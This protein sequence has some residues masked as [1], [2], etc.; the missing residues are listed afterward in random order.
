MAGW[1]GWAEILQYQYTGG[2]GQP[3]ALR[4]W[5]TAALKF[6][7]G[8]FDRILEPAPFSPTRQEL[9]DRGVKGMACLQEI[10]TVAPG[11]ADAYLEAVASRWL[12]VAERRGLTL[13][14]AWRTAMRDTEA[15]L[16]WSLPTFRAYTAHLADFRSAPET[17]AW[18]ETAR[19]WRTDHRET[20]IVPSIW[21]VTHPAWRGTPARA[22][23][24]RGRRRR[25]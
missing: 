3:P 16:L 13:I 22:A 5:W 12:P 6:R 14:G 15:V 2:A 19:T 20:L 1:D 21:C 9:V 8:G 25:R 17:R 10:A 4:K 23:R 18:A 24:P 11:R 7:S